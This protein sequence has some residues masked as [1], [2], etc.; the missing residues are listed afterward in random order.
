MNTPRGFTD[1]KTTVI[2]G[3]IA[4]GEVTATLAEIFREVGNADD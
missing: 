3:A 1:W 4:S 2:P